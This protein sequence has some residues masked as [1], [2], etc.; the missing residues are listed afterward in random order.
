MSKEGYNRYYS[1]DISFLEI[2]VL[3]LG[4][5]MILLIWLDIL[6]RHEENCPKERKRGEK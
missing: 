3:V 4:K 6:Q 5:D 2:Y 1:C